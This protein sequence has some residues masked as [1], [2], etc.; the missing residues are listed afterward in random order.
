MAI[1]PKFEPT[2]FKGAESWPD[3]REYFLGRI[4]EESI[5]K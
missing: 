4:V 3:N 2:R 1:L 5:K